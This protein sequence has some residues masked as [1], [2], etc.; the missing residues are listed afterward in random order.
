[1]LLGLILLP[2]I[3]V[4]HT[5]TILH[6]MLHTAACTSRSNRMFEL[7]ALLDGKVAPGAADLRRKRTLCFDKPK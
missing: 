3:P 1:M 2:H 4:P 7:A 6:R 5:V